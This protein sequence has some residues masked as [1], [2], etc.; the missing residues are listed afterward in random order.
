MWDFIFN[1]IASFRNCFSRAASFDWFS[2]TLIGIMI[3]SDKLG[4]TSVIR[5]LNLKGECYEKI[6]HFF[7]ADSWN[8]D[9]LHDH[10]YSLIQKYSV[11]YL[12]KGRPVFVIDG[13]KQSKEGHYMP[14]VK[15][16]ANDSDTQSKP[17][18]MHG[19]MGGMLSLLIG[20]AEKMASLPL[21]MTIQDGVKEMSHWEGSGVSGESHI[22]QM[23]RMT[24]EAVNHFKQNSVVLADRLFLTLTALS[25]IQKHNET[26]EYRLD[27][28]TKCKT[29]VVAYAK[30]AP[31]K[32]R[33]RPRKK[34][35]AF[36]LNHYFKYRDR[37]RKTTMKLYGVEKEVSY[38][39]C[40][41]LWGNKTYYE[42]RF[43]LVAYDNVTS[44]LATTDLSMSAEE[45]ISL[46]EH[47]FRIEHLFRSLK[48]I[49]GG[50]SYHFWTKAMPRLNRFRKKTDP[51]PLT[52]VTDPNERKRIISTLRATQMYLFIANVAIGI[53]MMV[54]IMYD[55]DNVQLR[56]QR[57]QTGKK[58]SEDNIHSYL[59][60]WIFWNLSSEAGKSINRAIISNQNTP[61]QSFHI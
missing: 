15:K 50:F 53:T 22:V 27:M 4:L 11:A 41:L 5:D 17:Q 32:G 13:T 55:F 26:S 56:Y 59:R 52:L 16:M 8:L 34:G 1:L 21:K 44:I 2:L 46:Y 25:E 51:D 42:L 29:N 36:R 47:R 24:S 20:T 30:P 7:R 23:F 28:V 43:V 35:R 10:W 60:K 18:T 3:R 14:G 9:T 58:P 33:G 54:S 49:Y 37:F 45:V 31:K 57:T 48:Q 38:L 19:H 40:N 61:D 12:H 6:M 39:A